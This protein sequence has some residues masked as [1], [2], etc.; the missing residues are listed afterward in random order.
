MKRLIIT[1]ID[2]TLKREK[3][4][5]RRFS[6]ISLTM[7]SAWILVCYSYIHDLIVRG[8]HMEAFLVMVGVATTMKTADAIGKKL[9]NDNSHQ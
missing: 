3:D 5:T 9:N 8:F 7:F 2:D 6:K 4:G 1:L